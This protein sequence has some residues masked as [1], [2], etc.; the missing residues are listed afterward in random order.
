MPAIE[1][2]IPKL[3]YSR[4]LHEA[5]PER[6]ASLNVVHSGEEFAIVDLPPDFQ[7]LLDE[8]RHSGF[9]V[10]SRVLDCYFFS[11]RDMA[12]QQVVAGA[13]FEYIAG[14][15]DETI[16]LERNLQNINNLVSCIA[17][18]LGGVKNRCI[19]DFGCGTGL[20][21]Q[22]DLLKTSSLI[23]FDLSPKMRQIAAARGVPSTWNFRDLIAASPGSVDGVF[24]S[25]VLHLMPSIET[26]SRLWAALREGGIFVGNCH[27]GEGKKFVEAFFDS[28][29]AE[30][31][32]FRIQTEGTHGPYVC[33]RKV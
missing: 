3:I 8:L 33:F 29:K 12:E 30:Y 15:Y 19:V 9:G 5:V 22:N 7:S 10:S 20:S 18:E 27:K 13:F 4:S 14:E 31:V 24:A 11:Y 25:Y 17:F 32:T 26:L 21:A 23:G 28:V 1:K 2:C 16:D 6:L